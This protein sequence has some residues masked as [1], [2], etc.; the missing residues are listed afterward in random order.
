MNWPIRE[1]LLA[2]LESLK[3]DAR[4]DYRMQLLAYAFAGGEKPPE[5]PAI[6]K[7]VDV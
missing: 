7:T 6:L 5:L 2:F 1:A 4:E 3:R